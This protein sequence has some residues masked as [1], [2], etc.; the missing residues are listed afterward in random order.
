[1]AKVNT[2]WVKEV[3]VTKRNPSHWFW[4]TWVETEYEDCGSQEMDSDNLPMKGDTVVGKYG[5][6]RVT[7]RIF[8]I[9][10]NSWKFILK[11]IKTF[12]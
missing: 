2:Y 12:E 8:Y 11:T 4:N 5:I 1:M 6:Y 9:E 10:D 7:D 3:K